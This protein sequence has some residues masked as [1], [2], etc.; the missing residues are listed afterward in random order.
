M[1]LSITTST[2]FVTAVSSVYTYMVRFQLKFFYNFFYFAYI[3]PIKYSLDKIAIT[4]NIIR[5]KSSS[6]T[7]KYEN[8]LRVKSPYATNFLLSDINNIIYLPNCI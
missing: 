4:I 2:L 1:A 7:L 8:S 3:S 5:I 6:E